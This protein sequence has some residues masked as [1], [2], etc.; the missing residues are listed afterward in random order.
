MK[1]FFKKILCVIIPFI[2]CVEMTITASASEPIFSLNEDEEASLFEVINDIEYQKDLLGLSDVN[3]NELCIG[4]PVQTYIYK[5]DT[6]ENG[7][8][9][10]PITINNNLIFWAI[11]HDGKFQVTT[12]LTSE[13][14]EKIDANTPFSIIYDKNSSYLFVDGRFV[15]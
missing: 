4:A 1:T 10:Y 3:F 14:N 6:F 5:N 8:Q 11:K 15:F 7:I 9:M 2:L 13:V 12:A